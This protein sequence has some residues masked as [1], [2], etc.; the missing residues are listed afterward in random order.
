MTALVISNNM[1]DKSQN[2]LRLAATIFRKGTSVL[3]P[4]NR[5]LEIGAPCIAMPDSITGSKGSKCAECT[6]RGHPCVGLTLDSLESA[7]SK[8][9]SELSEALD[10]QLPKLL[11]KIARL[12]KVLKQS[13]IRIDAKAKCLAQELADDNDGTEDEAP[14]DLSQFVNSLS[15]SF[16]DS[17][18]SPPQN[19][20]AS[21]RSS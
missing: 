18:V 11:A 7:R 6:H 21:S 17:I 10:E 19:I 12:R 13:E 5:C 2:R 1:K 14:P 20:E 9:E 16:W 8:T 15:P 4:C 3:V